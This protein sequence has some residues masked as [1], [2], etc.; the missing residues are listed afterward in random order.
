MLYK[1]VLGVSEELR[2][3][4]ESLKSRLV[5]DNGNQS[6]QYIESLIEDVLLNGVS[7]DN[8]LPI[9]IGFAENEGLDAYQLKNDIIVLLDVLKSVS[10]QPSKSEK[11]GIVFQAQRCHIGDNS[12]NDTRPVCQKSPN[13]LGLYDMSGNV[14]EWCSDWSGNY[15]SSSQTNPKGAA[16]GSRRVYR[17]GDWFS[18]F[19]YCRV[20]SRS[21][22]L[23]DDLGSTLGFRLA[24]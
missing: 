23:P 6:S 16:S 13:E 19:E 3:L 8:Q 5:T 2:Q 14:N 12:D 18:S 1:S 17:G 15:S 21:D 11:M 10:G 22:D 24:L 9:F 20:S 7:F 4:K